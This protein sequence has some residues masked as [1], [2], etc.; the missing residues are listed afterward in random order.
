MCFKDTQ[1]SDMYERCDEFYT[2]Y[3]HIQNLLYLLSFELFC[4]PIEIFHKTIFIYISNEEENVYR[5]KKMSQCD[6]RLKIV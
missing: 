1:P 6:I 4:S 2:K 3:H 5:I